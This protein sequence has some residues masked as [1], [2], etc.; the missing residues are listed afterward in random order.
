LDITITTTELIDLYKTVK[1][2]DNAFSIIS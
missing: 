2:S 1:G